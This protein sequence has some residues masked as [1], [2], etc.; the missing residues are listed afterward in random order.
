MA[1]PR[2]SRGIPYD[3]YVRFD[4]GKHKKS[5]VNDVIQED[6]GYI[7]WCLENIEGFELTD[8]AMAVFEN[9]TT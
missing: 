2:F 7:E 6:P 5:V 8:A 3:L 4:F 9:Q 1:R